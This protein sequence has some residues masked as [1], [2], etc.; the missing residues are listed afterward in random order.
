MEYNIS[1]ELEK[2]NVAQERKQASTFIIEFENGLL[3]EETIKL[4]SQYITEANLIISQ[5]GLTIH[6]TDPS[7]ISLIHL[8]IPK[9]VFKRFE[10][11]EEAQAIGVDIDLLSK[12]LKGSK[13]KTLKLQN[14]GDILEITSNNLMVQ[15][16]NIL[17]VA[18]NEMPSPK[19][20][21]S[22]SVTVKRKEFAAL[23]KEFNKTFNDLTLTAGEA[24]SLTA[25]NS[26]ASS[27]AKYT[28]E[29]KILVSL[30]AAKEIS[31]LYPINFILPFIE[32]CPTEAIT[33]SFSQDTPV[34]IR[35]AIPEL[36]ITFWIANKLRG[37]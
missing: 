27:S 4:V 6:E 10:A 30:D 31:A 21:F 24:F 32:K 18:K 16:I 3:L 13:N 2:D 1:D 11:P 22:A 34:E 20:N 14:F 5:D 23:L 12:I 36:K 9:R 17:E 26:E 33:M 37:D 29:N 8:E 28:K 7:Q 25:K 19:I 15:K 35:A